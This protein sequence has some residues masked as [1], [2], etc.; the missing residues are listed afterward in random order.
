MLHSIRPGGSWLDGKLNFSGGNG[1]STDSI[2]DY[3]R[4]DNPGIIEELFEEIESSSDFL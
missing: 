3:I 2:F 1:M 4:I